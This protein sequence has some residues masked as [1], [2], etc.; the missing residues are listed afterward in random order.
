[1]PEFRFCCCCLDSPFFF[2][3]VPFVK[4]KLLLPQAVLLVLYVR[5]LLVAP[6]L[7]LPPCRGP[8]P[9]SQLVYLVALLLS[10]AY[11]PLRL[12]QTPCRL[13]T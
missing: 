13:E 1:M 2:C 6:L 8:Q 12:S 9:Y 10:Q 5:S 4:P 11:A 7:L 3:D